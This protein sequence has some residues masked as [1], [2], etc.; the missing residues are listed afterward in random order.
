M[1]KIFNHLIYLRR[2]CWYFFECFDF[3]YRLEI[4]S[5]DVILDALSELGVLFIG[6][7][8]FSESIF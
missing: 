7:S 5:K 2:T 6:D 3:L 1:D 4:V 8:N